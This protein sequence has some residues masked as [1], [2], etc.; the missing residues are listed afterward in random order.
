M[1]QTHLKPSFVEFIPDHLEDG[2][3]YISERF[4]TCSHN[5]CCGCGEEVVLPLSPAEWQLNRDG[6]TVSLWPSVGNWD[7]ACKSHYVI[8]RNQVRWAGSM[9][10]HQIKRV[11]QRD[12]IAL[13]SQIEFAN[14]ARAREE[15]AIAD[16]WEVC[17]PTAA[18]SPN[19]GVAFTNA[20][21]ASVWKR[22]LG[23]FGFGR[24]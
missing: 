17:T 3:L 4:R 10:A 8:R 12:Q 22:L 2:V 11:K 15:R 7:Y 18:S 13:L 1:R 20:P 23:L 19:A 16:T 14:A 5:C 21:R 24:V 9:T 6:D